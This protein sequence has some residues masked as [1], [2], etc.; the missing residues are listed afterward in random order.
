MPNN[1]HIDNTTVIGKIA[2]KDGEALLIM[3][4]FAAL[5]TNIFRINRRTIGMRTKLVIK[6]QTFPF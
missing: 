5:I 1:D 6:L 3:D 4:E 2:Y